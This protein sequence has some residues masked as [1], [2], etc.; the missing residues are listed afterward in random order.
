MNLFYELIQSKDKNMMR[1][2]I[3]KAI[4]LLLRFHTKVKY[5]TKPFFCYFMP[6]GVPKVP[7][8]NPGEDDLSWI[9]V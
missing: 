6:I 2:N 9:D 4:K 3:M 5:S 1:A 8:R 7:F